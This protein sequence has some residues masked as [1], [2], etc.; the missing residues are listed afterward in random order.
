M[1]GSCILKPS[2]RNSKGE[3]G[4]SK[5]FN[6]LLSHFPKQRTEAWAYYEMAIDSKFKESLPSDVRYDDNGEILFRDFAEIVGLSDEHFNTLKALNKELQEG[7]YGFTDATEKVAVFNRDQRADS[8]YMATLTPTEDSNSFRIS[9]V[10]KTQQE[11]QNL[12][13]LVEGWHITEKLRFRLAQA[14]VSA[15]FIDED[16]SRYNTKNAKENANGLLE[17]VEFGKNST[18]IQQTEEA[19]HFIV[20]AM[21]GHPLMDRLISLMS[22]AVMDS[23][24]GSARSI[25]ENAQR[26][27]AGVIVGQVLKREFSNT[28]PIAKI[29]SRAIQY[30]KKQIAKISANQVK[31]DILEAQEIAKKYV[32]DFR[33]GELQGDARDAI[34]TVETLY[35]KA[36]R[37]DEKI[38]HELVDKLASFA[39]EIKSVNP[40]TAKELDSIILSSSNLLTP[41]STVASF[42]YLINVLSP[43][44]QSLESQIAQDFGALGFYGIEA[45]ARIQKSAQ[46]LYTYHKLSEFWKLVSTDMNRIKVSM[47]TDLKILNPDTDNAFKMIE[48]FLTAGGD[49]FNRI[50]KANAQ[51]LTIAFLTNMYGAKEVAI[52]ESLGWESVKNIQASTRKIEDIVLTLYKDDTWLS[53][54]AGSL[55]NSVDLG[56][57]FLDSA[58]KNAQ[59]IA[60]RNTQEDFVKL[61]AL[62]QEA[63]DLGITSFDWCYEKDDNGN[64]T[65]NLIT[66]LPS[67]NPTSIF[68]TS[69][70]I[71][72][73]SN[74]QK[75]YEAKVNELLE[76]FTQTPE[77]KH[78][79]QM[80]PRIRVL[81][82]QAWAAEELRKWKKANRA[83]LTGLNNTPVLQSDLNNAKPADRVLRENQIQWYLK[84]QEAWADIRSKI[85]NVMPASRAP[86]IKAERVDTIK[87][88]VKYDRQNIFSATLNQ[89]KEDAVE[90]FSRQEPELDIQEYST[91]YSNEG[92][93]E[94]YFNV[95]HGLDTRRSKLL[96]LYYTKPLKNP[97]QL[98]TNLLASTMDF[99]IM[100]NKYQAMN[101]VKEVLDISAQTLQLRN[102]K[103]TSDKN[104]GRTANRIRHAINKHVYGINEGLFQDLGRTVPGVVKIINKASNAASLWLLGFNIASQTVNL[105]TGFIEMAKEGFAGEYY[106]AED[107]TLAYKDY[108]KEFFRNIGDILSGY[109]TS[110]VNLIGQKFDLFDKVDVSGDMFRSWGRRVGKEA[111]SRAAMAGYSIADH[112]MQLIPIM[113]MMRHTKL[114]TIDGKETN[115]WEIYKT[116]EKKGTT[117]LTQE[118]AF[119][120]KDNI[121]LYKDLLSAVE[122]ITNNTSKTVKNSTFLTDRIKDYFLNQNFDEPTINSWNKEE[123][124]NILKTRIN[125]ITFSSI[126]EANFRNKAREV[127]NRMH[128]VYNKMDSPRL[129]DTLPGK[130]WGRM[131]RYAFGMIRKRYGGLLDFKKGALNVS[132]SLANDDEGYRTTLIRLSLRSFMDVL[133]SLKDWVSYKGRNDAPAAQR[134]LDHLKRA[135]MTTGFILTAPLWSTS[136]FKDKT[137]EALGLSKNQVINIARNWR[138][139]AI[140]LSL[141]F[142]KDWLKTMAAGAEDEEELKEMDIAQIIQYCK[143]HNIE[144]SMAKR[145]FQYLQR[146]AKDTGE[147]IEDLTKEWMIDKVLEV[148]ADR[149]REDRPAAQVAYYFANRLL[150]E[151]AAFNSW[152][153]ASVESRALLDPMPIAV[154]FAQDV[155]SLQD[156]YFTTKRFLDEDLSIGNG[157]T[158]SMIKAMELAGYTV[159]ELQEKY[160]INK[161]QASNLRKDLTNRIVKHWTSNDYGTKKDFETYFM[162]RAKRGKYRRLEPK[163][164][165]T[166]RMKLP[167]EKMSYISTEGIQATNDYNFGT[168]YN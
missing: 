122:Q 97:N 158:V 10:E 133:A 7:V 164:R 135:G 19:G 49:Y 105:G 56:A 149:A 101:N 156:G 85:G 63:K 71:V 120:D 24:L 35:H 106:S 77:G 13:D 76:E 137:A 48:T 92:F 127:T 107:F 157:Q 138:D 93:A 99:A 96:P 90:F 50:Y 129:F 66:L 54:M 70:I 18:P 1:N 29:A 3:L 148:T 114:Y 9:V 64:L 33:R 79:L 124:L 128:G 118:L 17:L 12:Q 69:Y 87:N 91:Y 141:E 2:V 52:Q 45:A 36:L 146:K 59:H 167:W 103:T 11:V 144:I 5:L 39:E 60:N 25:S 139:T 161:S 163:W 6:D 88:R 41:F 136:R 61:K 121:P 58:I 130:L 80:S 16:Y 153:A 34:K 28:S 27:A 162:P 125:Q 82:F 151:Q 160:N 123:L 74:Y 37:E 57:Q 21:T 143:E 126:D 100:A 72:N 110:K 67:P 51:A 65:G 155:L 68:N 102:I 75:A 4:E 104:E 47:G 131:T 89:V 115:L 113:A 55:A 132:A 166:L 42:A 78:Y 147:S 111:V 38:Y 108:Y 8:K 94:H 159:E 81:K 32:E 84:Y 20:G 134:A 73:T 152:G 168:K 154:G 112:Q 119:K 117:T 23:V 116:S 46:K 83:T 22:P 86:Q 142:L 145:T 165:T 26:E 14:G 43:L 31:L 150:R 44:I 95:S 15:T 40:K 30:F 98:D 109:N 62:Q 53:E 140:I